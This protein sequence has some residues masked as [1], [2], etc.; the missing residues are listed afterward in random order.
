MLFV[1]FNRDFIGEKYASAGIQTNDLPI[2]I[3]FL[4]PLLF[5]MFV[6][7]RSGIYHHLF[8][9]PWCCPFDYSGKIW[10]LW[11]IKDSLN[12]CY[13]HNLKNLSVYVYFLT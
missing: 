10:K 9:S 3:V 5:I 4:Q 11:V 8:Q 2:H 1:V 13:S 7:P 12:S 6:W